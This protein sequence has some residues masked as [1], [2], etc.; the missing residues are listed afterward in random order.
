MYIDVDSVEIARMLESSIVEKRL[1]SFLTELDEDAQLLNMELRTQGLK[2][3]IC[4][5]KNNENMPGPFSKSQLRDFGT[6]CDG[7]VRYVIDD[8][9]SPTHMPVMVRSFLQSFCS[10]HKV[11]Y[12]KPDPRYPLFYSD[13]SLSS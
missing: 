3:T 5:I 11:I 9:P 4:T 10:L 6:A 13:I 8:V 7:N 2:A 1:M 12:L